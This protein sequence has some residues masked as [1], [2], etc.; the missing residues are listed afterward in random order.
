MI[1]GMPRAA[2]ADDPARALALEDAAKARVAQNDKRVAIDLYEEAYAASPRRE[3]LREMGKLY[4]ELAYGG[5]SRDVRL[6]ILYLERYL[7]G[8]AVVPDRAEVEARLTRLRGWKAHMRAEPQPT[9][10]PSVVPLHMLAYDGKQKYEV[11]VAGQVCTTPCTLLVPPGPATLLARGPGDVNAQL[12]VPPRAGQVRVQHVERSAFIAGAVL[13]P[14]GITVGASLWTIAFACSD[15]SGGCQVAN[16]VIWPT[17]GASAMITGIVLLATSRNTASPDANRVEL[18]ARGAA[19]IR[20]T[21]F[22]LAPI[23]G[24]GTLGATFEF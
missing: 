23:P 13:I 21:S 8:D 5:D 15:S 16:L 6:A 2:C 14:A 9:P 3:Y 4:D 18:V 24:G 19:P 10:P 7:A 11:A 17:L 20:L 12:L 22:G 1:A